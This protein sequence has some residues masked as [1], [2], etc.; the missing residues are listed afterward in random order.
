MRDRPD[1]RIR[2]SN[3][4]RPRRSE[5]RDD[6]PGSRH[7]ANGR[8]HPS[9]QL[10]ALT[11]VSWGARAHTPDGE[12]AVPIF[13]IRR[14][15]L[16][17]TKATDH[18]EP[19]PFLT[20]IVTLLFVLTIAY[21]LGYLALSRKPAT[22]PTPGDGRRPFAVFVVPCLDEELVIGASLDRLAAIPG[23]D[24]AVLVID[25]GSSDR[26]SEIVRN[27]LSDR[28][29]LLRREAPDARQGKGEALNHAY[30]VLRD[31]VLS[32]RFGDRTPDEI[33][34]VVLDAD[35]RVEHDVL[36]H[37]LPW[38]A[39]PR[40]GAVQIGVR[41][42]NADQGLLPRL[43]DM[44]FVTYL[45]IF[46]RARHRL[47]SSGLGG[48]GQFTRLSALMGL[49]D[50]PWTTCLTEDLDLGVRLL[51]MGWRNAFCPTTHVRQQAVT[52]LDRLLRQR[53]RWFQGH[54]QCMTL[55]PSIIRSNRLTARAAFDLALTL[56][57]AVLVLVT[58]IACAG[59]A[60]V[61]MAAV[62]SGSADT[63]LP[64]REGAD[65]VAV[66]AGWYLL[67]FGLAPLYAS[68]Y[69]RHEPTI[70]YPRALWLGHVYSLYGYLWFASGW[71]AVAR[72]VT[73][74]DGWA[75]TRRT[76]DVPSGA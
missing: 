38:F 48:N 63:L 9:A 42:Y 65:M 28:V 10:D 41:M 39:D 7:Y 69:R 2:G 3:G 21:A 27:R 56:Q 29:W 43:Q 17:K 58:S 6:T 34:V 50:K 32:G 55:V 13:L 60:A 72:L 76:V 18:E 24:S 25:D 67:A 59:L 61:L 75:K 62:L 70:G 45:D 5:G 23:D 4:G 15:R 68:I 33:V 16:P 30:Q 74:R 37:T 31:G 51:T 12:G 36:D 52:E 53:T 66:I 57:G 35:G 22:P 49:G 11:V 47:G 19:E 1:Q 54:L 14:G 44:E 8:S 71:R 64:N 73:G 40:I 46:Q 20:L 26:T